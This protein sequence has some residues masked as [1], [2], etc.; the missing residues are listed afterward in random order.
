MPDNAT[1]KAD[2]DDTIK[3]AQWGLL[4]VDQGVLHRQRPRAGG[5]GMSAQRA[6]W[7][8]AAAARYALLSHGTGAE[9]EW[10]H[11]RREGGVRNRGET[12]CRGAR[13]KDNEAT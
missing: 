3:G 11:G 8:D 10:T 13:N 4:H 2:P 6:S 7:R 12:T 9:E 5:D 1:K